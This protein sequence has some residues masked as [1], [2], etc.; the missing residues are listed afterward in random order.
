MKISHDRIFTFSLMVLIFSLAV[1]YPFLWISGF[2]I[3]Y[4]DLIFLFVFFI[5]ITGLILKKTTFRWHN[6]FWLLLFY[7]GALLISVIFSID[8][9]KSLYKFFGEIYLVLLTVLIFNYVRTLEETKKILLAWFAGTM[10]ALLIGIFTIFLF[11]FDGENSLLGIFL[12]H[13]GTVP[14]GNYPRIRGTFL[15]SN[16]LAN[17]LNASLMLALAGASLG[18]INSKFAKIF[19]SLIVLVSLFTFSPGL[20]GIALGL[21][22]FGW[23]FF[24]SKNRRVLAKSSLIGGIFIAGVFL[25]LLTISMQKHP[26]A[27]FVVGIPFTEKVVYPS[28]RVMVWT[29]S[30]QTFIENPL[31]GVGLD[32]DACRVR[33][34]NPS[35]VLEDLR[36]AHNILLNVAAQTG[37]FGLIAMLAI[38]FYFLRKIFDFGNFDDDKKVFY[39][40][41]GLAILT[42]FIYQGVGGSF[43]ETRHLWVIFGLFLSAD[44]MV[45][46][47]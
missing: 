26:T 11:Y 30:F 32:Q 34:L 5:W 9:Q 47:N 41:C 2:R 38:I 27:P 21:G 10:F 14:V 44:K 7:L 18:W 46:A 3:P 37:I 12:N 40:A 4:T 35:G 29:A 33:Y 13:Y 23:L 36:E 19:I 45:N 24:K 1:H 43:E 17:Y 42:A 39:I 31:T 25:V 28:S 8:P 22:I 6:F 20:G 15:H 16:M